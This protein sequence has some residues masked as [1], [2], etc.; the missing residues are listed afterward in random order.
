MKKSIAIAQPHLIGV[1]RLCL[2]PS[3]LYMYK[4]E[5][6][7][8]RAARPLEFP[9]T[10]IRKCG[11]TDNYF[12]IEFGRSSSTGPGEMWML[13]D[14]VA[15]AHNMHEKIREAMKLS[16]SHEDVAPLPPPRPRSESVSDCS[17]PGSVY[18]ASYDSS[19]LSS[20]LVCEEGGY[21]EMDTHGARDEMLFSSHAQASSDDDAYLTMAPLSSS[22]PN[23][24]QLLGSSPARRDMSVMVSASQVY[25]IPC[26]PRRPVS[27][28]SFKFL[29]AR[30]SKASS[31]GLILTPSA[32]SSHRRRRSPRPPSSRSRR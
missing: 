10:A 31:E 13:V 12:C 14:E 20:G 23:T 5:V 6:G 4:V 26:F 29:R 7:A 15:V 1:Q 28:D 32:F 25:T 8:E 21:V 22:L 16:K 18:G 11:H 3:M 17:S 2:T 19:R 30:S 9:L 24:P 27:S